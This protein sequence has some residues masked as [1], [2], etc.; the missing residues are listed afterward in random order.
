MLCCLTNRRRAAPLCLPSSIECRPSRPHPP[1]TRPTSSPQASKASW[2]RMEWAA[3][4]RLTQVSIC[5]DI[6]TVPKLLACSFKVVTLSSAACSLQMQ[7][8]KCLSSTLLRHPLL[9]CWDILYIMFHSNVT[10]PTPHAMPASLP[11]A[12]YTII[13]FPFLFAVMFGDMGHGLLMTCAALYLVL[14]ESRLMAQKNDSEVRIPS[15]S[16]HQPYTI[17]TG[18][19]PA[20]ELCMGFGAAVDLFFA[21]FEWHIWSDPICHWLFCDRCSAW[22][23]QAVTSSCSW[24]SSQST[25]GSFTTTVSLS[26]STL[27]ALAGVSGPCL[28]VV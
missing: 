21:C 24:E 12:P 7:S 19:S 9:P 26:H 13:T 8:E 28:T 4:V 20:P 3:T 22:C 1:I 27:L 18:D 25:L 11:P 14:R 15:W 5:Q 17:I 23:F 16:S 6:L 10:P 2:M